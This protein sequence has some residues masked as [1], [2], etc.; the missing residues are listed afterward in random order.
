MVH[1]SETALVCPFLSAQVQGALTWSAAP[2]SVGIDL[3][4]RWLQAWR[5]ARHVLVGLWSCASSGACAVSRNEPL[6]RQRILLSH[7]RLPHRC[8]VIGFCPRGIQLSL[9]CPRD[10]QSSYSAQEASS[11]LSPAP[12]ISNSSSIASD[13]PNPDEGIPTGDMG[14]RAGAWGT[15]SI[16]VANSSASK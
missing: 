10:V 2:R 15:A 11:S 1:A 12:E 6:A 3:V 5:L 7:A 13:E 14:S 9:T 4:V 16:W 8:P